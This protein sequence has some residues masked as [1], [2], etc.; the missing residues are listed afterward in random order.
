MSIT[1]RKQ[2]T[3]INSSTRSSQLRKKKEKKRKDK[4]KKQ[5]DRQ[6][7]S[8][9]KARL[10][11]VRVFKDILPRINFTRKKLNNIPNINVELGTP[12]VQGSSTIKSNAARLI[13]QK[14]KEKLEHDLKK[15]SNVSANRRKNKIMCREKFYKMR[16]FLDTQE[17]STNALHKYHKNTPHY[18]EKAK[19]YKDQIPI[20][21]YMACMGDSPFTPTSNDESYFRG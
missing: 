21:K 16:K 13:Q 3:Y 2:S 9:R 8:K 4:E 6:K 20:K 11:K 14:F 10:V 18:V 5:K 15:A 17:N 1:Q 19:K 12:R 7:K